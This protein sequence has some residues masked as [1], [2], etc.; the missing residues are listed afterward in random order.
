MQD[1]YP[2]VPEYAIDPTVRFV[3]EAEAHEFI[4]FVKNVFCREDE[5]P[6]FT[7]SK[8]VHRNSGEATVKAHTRGLRTAEGIRI[9]PVKAHKR[10]DGD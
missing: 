9:V 2:Q 3:T 10:G 6:I 4:D 1:F 5:R 8:I 7:M